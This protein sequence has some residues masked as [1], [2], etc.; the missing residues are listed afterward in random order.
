MGTTESAADEW[1]DLLEHTVLEQGRGP[2][3]FTGAPTIH[4][5]GGRELA[6]DETWDVLLDAIAGASLRTLSAILGTSFAT[7][8]TIWDLELE[9][10]REVGRVLRPDSELNR[11]YEALIA[12]LTRYTSKSVIVV[13]LGG[14]YSSAPGPIPISTHALV[15]HVS[16]S[17][18]LA[19]A[20]LSMLAGLDGFRFT[21][22]A[23]W[24]EDFLAAEEDGYFAEE[25]AAREQEEG[26]W[27]PLVLAIA[28]DCVGSLAGALGLQLA[29][30]FLGAAMLLED[31]SRQH[32]SVSPWVLG[33]YSVSEA[34]R[35]PTLGEDGVLGVKPLQVDSLP[36]R[37]YK[38][39]SSLG[40]QFILDIDL[41]PLAKSSQGQLLS[42]VTKISPNGHST[43]SNATTMA[44]RAAFFG[45]Q[46]S[47]DIQRLL[48]NSALS[49]LTGERT[50][51]DFLIADYYD[52][53]L[54][55]VYEE[56]FD[57]WSRLALLV[58]TKG[59]G[60]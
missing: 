29:E 8:I 6:L 20:E 22:E 9:L 13:P 58:R 36:M 26:L 39:V 11:S 59:D 45:R 10:V 14:I 60:T 18:E 17:T 7:R 5:D 35:Y 57:L 28:L 23:W 12:R 51:E 53:P 21:D 34:S 31:D 40:D 37:T 19:I 41:A 49:G 33:S 27:Q 1:A 48:F 55:S 43:G 38:S 25:L 44:C 3:R 16:R 30:A 32:F 50:D 42:T 52:Q 56:I 15:G 54:T 46:A 24:T 2:L 4:D 47:G